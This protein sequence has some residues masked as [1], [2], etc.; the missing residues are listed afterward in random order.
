MDIWSTYLGHL[1]VKVSVN[2]KIGVYWYFTKGLTCENG[3]WERVWTLTEL[4]VLTW[5]GLD[6]ETYQENQFLQQIKLERGYKYDVNI[7]ILYFALV[8]LNMINYNWTI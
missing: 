4:K 1:C 6:T 5:I 2:I 8:T 7:F 3:W